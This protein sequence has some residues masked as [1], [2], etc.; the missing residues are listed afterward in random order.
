[1][2]TIEGIITVATTGTTVESISDKLV[3]AAQKIAKESGVDINVQFAAEK[4]K[5]ATEFAVDVAATANMVLGS[6]YAY[7]SRSG[8]T[9]M[10]G[11][12]DYSNYL[13]AQ[14]AGS[15]LL[16]PQNGLSSTASLDSPHQP[17][18]FGNFSTARRVEPYE[19]DNVVFKGAE[20]G[21]L[22]GAIYE[23]DTVSSCH[24][25]GHSLVA[26]GT[27]ANVVWMVTDAVMDIDQHTSAYRHHGDDDSTID[28]S[29][30]VAMIRTITIRGFDASDESVDREA[31]L[32]DI[33]TA[34]PEPMDDATTNKVIFHK[35]LLSIARQIYA[36]TKIYIDWMSPNH[37]IVLNGHSV[38]GSLSILM[39]LLITN[40]KGV[41]YVHDRIF[42]VYS[43]G[44]PPVAF[45]NTTIVKS[46]DE[47]IECPILEA[48]GL[49]ASIVYGYVQPYDP[50]VRLFSGHDVLYPLVDDLGADGITLYSTGPI[51]S[52]RPIAKAIF[53]ISPKQ[54][55][56]ALDSTF[57]LDTFKVSLVPQAV[58]SF[59]HH[60]YPAYNS[61]LSEYATKV[62]K[63][64]GAY[65]AEQQD[66]EGIK[67]SNLYFNY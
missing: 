51:R 43:H 56:P 37:R 23:E 8:V 33:C 35:G 1:M 38:G 31:V 10:E 61:S 48:F 41:D 55:L 15:A 50:I 28:T 13:A 16:S 20:M 44:S 2:G 12:D 66:Q 6:G 18:L 17:P 54:L 24:K 45:M 53:Q 30:S 52:L 47:N 58:R 7:G 11:R 3:A 65:P 46:E 5:E 36:D 64:Y 57:P 62:A 25:L 9:G 22:A 59:L 60:F 19:Y 29:S 27:T 49:P 39:L 21:G 26:N 34:T 4:A 40:E 63:E 14:T 42:R 67:I 32:N